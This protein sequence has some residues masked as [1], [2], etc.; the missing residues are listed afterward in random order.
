[1][2]YI[3]SACVK[4]NKIKDSVLDLV[5]H[6]FL[7]IELSGGSEKYNNLES[8]LLKLQDKYS[9]NYLC[10]NYFPPPTEHFVLNLASLNDDVFQKSYN[11]IKGS[12]KL[13][14]TLGAQ[15]FAFH[16][17]FFIDIKPK[18]IGKKITKAALFDKDKSIK[19][20][21]DAYKRL[22]DYAGDL[23]LYVENNVFSHTNYQ[24]FKGENFFM[25][26]NFE[27]YLELKD[28]IN[29][30]LLLDVAH[31]KV[32]TKTLGLDFLAQLNNLYVNTDYIHVSDNDSFHDINDPI[33]V[34]SEFLDTFKDSKSIEKQ[35]TLEVYSSLPKIRESHTILDRI[36][37]N[38]NQLKV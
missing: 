23:N 7:N 35:Y 11:H 30:N 26:T 12:I 9:I 6:G 32:S 21:T 19:K 13:S 10:H 33:S 8:D 18:E 29:F 24:N 36:I 34:D 27:D 28:K 25:L 37:S 14:K 2:I 15:K 5:N 1:M 31:L 22:Q 20:F 16:A 4:R 3:S 17:G 38:S